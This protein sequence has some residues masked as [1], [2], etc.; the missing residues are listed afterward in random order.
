MVQQLCA[1]G[2][3]ASNTKEMQMPVLERLQQAVTESPPKRYVQRRSGESTRAA[4]VAW[5]IV[6][7]T[8]CYVTK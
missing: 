3:A 6:D 1:L 2:G 5:G 4:T 8:K 7:K